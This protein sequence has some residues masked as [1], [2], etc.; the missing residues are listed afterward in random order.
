[1]Q[2]FKI[3]HGFTTDPKWGIIAHQI[4]IPRAIVLAVVV[5]LLEYASK[6]PVR[7]SVS[8]YDEEEGA[9]NLGVDRNALRNVIDALRNRGFVTDGQ[10]TNWEE[11]QGVSDPTN[12]ERQR[13]HRDK[14]RQ[15]SQELDSHVTPSNALRNTDK[16]REDKK[17]EEEIREEYPIITS[18]ARA[19]AREETPRERA[20][21]SN[22]LP[23]AVKPPD[24]PKYHG[25][26]FH[27]RYNEVREYITGRVP[28]LGR[29]NASEV[30]R[31]LMDGADADLDVIP[32]VDNALQFKDAKQIKS[33][34]YFTRDIVSAFAARKEN[35]ETIERM[36]RKYAEPK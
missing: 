14:K 22:H 1:M 25:T 13:R 19:A 36:R 17:R 5:D 10:I 32:S 27:P 15:E 18:A 9:Y 26:T 6:S 20:H 30:N 23:A 21:V 2:W 3:R 24:T 34:N 28:Q 12:A 7:G 31:W 4:S 8:G 35:A 29:Q 11:Y 33:F 16:I